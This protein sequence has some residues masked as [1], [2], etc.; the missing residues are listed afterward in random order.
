MTVNHFKAMIVTENPDGNFVREIGLREIN[1]LPPGEVLI[2]V[3]YSSLN[4]KDAL[5]A[6]GNKGV[7]RKYPHTPGVDAAGTVIESQSS[8]FSTGDSVLVTGYDLGMNTSG[9][10]GAYIRVPA[11]WV[12]K[13]PEDLSV[14]ESMVYGTAGFTAGLSVYKLVMAG[15][16][17]AAGDILVTGASGGVGSLA[18]CILAK[19]GYEVV[20][21]TGKPKYGSLLKELGANTVISR[22]E[23]M[24]DSKRALLPSRWAAVVDTV[25]GTVLETALRTTMPKGLVTCC[26]NVASA[27]LHLTVYPFILRGISLFGVDSAETPMPL[28]L[29]IWD[30]LAKE[31]KPDILERVY[32]EIPLDELDAEIPK[33][34]SGQ[35]TGR[36]L[37]RVDG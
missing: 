4:Y 19:A 21:A 33:M 17:P 16:D 1:S 11:D 29:K 35:Q 28:R 26:G 2:H 31:W 14:K 24:D 7:T 10:F 18:V 6:T 25:G 9:G 23:I 36:R 22:E 34:L 27:E 8:K 20:A 12:V 13:L 32:S 30:K 37:V 5:S 3:H 15:L